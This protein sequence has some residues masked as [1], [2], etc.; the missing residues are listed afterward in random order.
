MAT[1]LPAITGN[2]LVELLQ[3]DGWVIQ[4]KCNHGL[5]MSKEID[6]RRIVTVVPTKK[7]TSLP[8]GTLSSILGSKQTRIGKDG[9]RK[10]IEKYG[11]N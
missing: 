3:K 10:L 5:S 11:L 7:N 2:Q 9:L 8:D 1:P 6:G 4:R